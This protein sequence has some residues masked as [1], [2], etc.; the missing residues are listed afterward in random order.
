MHCHE[1]LAHDLRSRHEKVIKGVRSRNIRW[2]SQNEPAVFLA[3]IKRHSG[4][5]NVTNTVNQGGAG[6]RRP[7]FQFA[8]SIQVIDK[9]ANGF[10]LHVVNDY[11]RRRQLLGEKWN[12]ADQIRAPAGRGGKYLKELAGANIS[13]I[14]G[15]A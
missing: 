14:P 15:V 3:Q 12:Y 10:L 2:H 11:N 13:M 5:M 4:G 6:F 7:H 9:G 8:P 1:I